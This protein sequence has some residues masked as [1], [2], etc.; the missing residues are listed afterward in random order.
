MEGER[1]WWHGGGR[2]LHSV[3]PILRRRDRLERRLLGYRRKWSGGGMEE[4]QKW[5]VDE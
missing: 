1:R 2:G 4:E 5:I 3:L